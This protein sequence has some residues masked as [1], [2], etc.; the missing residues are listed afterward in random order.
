MIC[1]VIDKDFYII[2]IFNKYNNFD[3]YSHNE[4]EKIIKEF[5]EKYLKK[6]NLKGNIT[7]NIYVD[8]LYGMIFEIKKTS[9]SLIDKLIDIKIKF[10]LNI[11]F[12]YEID[13]FYLIENKINNQNIYFN[14]DKFYLELI[15]D[16]EEKEYI[17]LLDNSLIIYNDSINNI[18]NNGIKLENNI[19]IWYY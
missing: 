12:L 7:F 14:K 2:K 17:K 5:F 8:K 15:N 1:N 6:Y 4:I 16:I 10:N 11:S 3:I 13:Y 9:D 18:I 19:K